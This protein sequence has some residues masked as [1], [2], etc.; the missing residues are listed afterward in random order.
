MPR[1]PNFTS[2][3]AATLG[4]QG[5]LAEQQ[6]R[7]KS[8]EKMGVARLA[9]GVAKAIG[10]QVPQYQETFGLG[11]D[12]LKINRHR[13][14]SDRM[15]ALAAK[16][17]AEKGLPDIGMNDPLA[18]A[19]AA[20]R[21][22]KISPHRASM[23]PEDVK[24]VDLEVRRGAQLGPVEQKIARWQS[25]WESTFP[26]YGAGTFTPEFMGRMSPE[27]IMA[28]GVVGRLHA[29][30][31]YYPDMAKELL[32]RYRRG[33]GAEFDPLSY[34]PV[35]VPDPIEEIIRRGR[36]GENIEG[37]APT[38]RNIKNEAEIRAAEERNR[39]NAINRMALKSL[40]EAA[41]E[42]STMLGAYPSQDELKE[43][44]NLLRERLSEILSERGI[45]ST[46]YHTLEEL[47]RRRRE[48]R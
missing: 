5:A 12:Q 22:S 2:G 30:D 37:I 8:D 47:A 27:E 45:D 36:P 7:R 11:P 23:N 44:Q 26:G 9:L 17:R 48:G 20:D 38:I 35:P 4:Q 19:D 43:Y 29:E 41:G 13:A 15:A 39:L 42:P 6:K 16:M 3:I 1:Y 32:D 34:S 40:L 14:V 18:R 46:A 25:M 10:E 21:F 33:G 24:A 28:L 31:A